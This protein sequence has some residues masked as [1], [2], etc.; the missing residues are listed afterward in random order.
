[1][2]QVLDP[3]R[4]R[5]AA[6]QLRWRDLASMRPRDGLVECLHPLPWLSASLAFFALDLWPLGLL[7]EFMF[8][9]TALRLNHEAIHHNLGF[10]PQG[11]RMVLHGLSLMMLGSNHSVAFNHMRHHAHINTERDLEGKA[12]KMSLIRV[13]AYGPLFPIECHLAALREGGP[14]WRRKVGIDLLLNM[15]L[16]AVAIV[17]SVDAIAWH[18]GTMLVA[19]CFTALFAVWITHR[20]CQDS[21]LVARSQRNRL[22]NAVSYNM[23]F[24][25]EHH[26]FPAVPVRRLPE[27]ARRLDRVLPE[28]KQH[29]K[30]VVGR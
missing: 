24:H 29:L 23:F 22:V 14:V 5:Q 21:A 30:P 3:A 7:C 20:G 1:M 12:G 4:L 26:L 25:L 2:A 13:L 8:F 28:L 15:V 9:L 17:W 27:L 11:H 6:R 18:F 16:P 19:Q 10:S